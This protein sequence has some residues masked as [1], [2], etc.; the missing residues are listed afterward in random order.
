MDKADKQNAGQ[1]AIKARFGD[2]GGSATLLIGLPSDRNPFSR[3]GLWSL[4]CP[5]AL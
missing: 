2:G 1:R 3:G 4:R 5:G